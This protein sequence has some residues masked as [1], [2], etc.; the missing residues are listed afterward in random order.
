MV[1]T[2]TIVY[3]ICGEEQWFTHFEIIFNNET[4]LEIVD[5][6]VTSLPS[7]R[8]SKRTVYGIDP[9]KTS[10]AYYKKRDKYKKEKLLKAEFLISENIKTKM[11]LETKKFIDKLMD[12]NF[13]H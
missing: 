6:F 8:G 4:E 3:K 2:L 12:R 13:V 7:W 1:K 5:K 9:K 11:P 10:Y